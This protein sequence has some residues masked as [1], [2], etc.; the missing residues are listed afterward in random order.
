MS[1]EFSSLVDPIFQRVLHLQERLQQGERPELQ[2]ERS[3]IRNEIEEAEKTAAAPDSKVRIEEFRLAKQALIY[4]TDEVLTEAWPDWED[5]LLEVEYYGPPRKRAWKFY[6]DGETQARHAS[7][8]V[9]EVWYLALVMGFQG[10]IRD[11][12]RSH[13]NREMPGNVDDEQEA[14]RIWIRQLEKRLRQTSTAEIAGEPL[15]GH[16]APLYGKAI[17]STGIAVAVLLLAILGVLALW[18]QN[19]SQ[20]GW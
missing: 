14:R 6:V 1:P 7:P 8:D 12:F 10:D 13:L 15:Y 3:D 11:A 4:W 2:T 18:W 17:L 16:V 19:R 9:A 5:V 20:P